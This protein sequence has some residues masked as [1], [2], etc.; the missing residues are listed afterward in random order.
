MS[1][2]FQ[3]VTCFVVAAV[4]LSAVSAYGKRERRREGYDPADML[5]RMDDNKNGMIEPSEISGPSR[6]FIDRA[7]EKASLDKSKAMP[8]DKLLPAMQ[9]ISE[10]YRKQR[11]GG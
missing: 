5:R 7:A 8:I 11:D 1:I 3:P 4:F 9:A 2:R 6:M 10:E